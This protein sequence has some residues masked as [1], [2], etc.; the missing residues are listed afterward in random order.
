MKNKTVLKIALSGMFLALGIVLPFLT[1][2]IPEIGAMLC[3]MHIPVIIC[4]FICGWKYGLIMGLI[5]PI[6]RSLM[7]SMPPMYPGA[8]SFA[9]EYGVY[10]LLSGLGFGL[11]KKLN[12][13]NIVYIYIVLIVTMI[14]GRVTWGIARYLIA[15]VDNTI[16]FNITMF[17]AGAFVNAWP[18]IILQLILIP[19]LIRSLS[20]AGLIEKID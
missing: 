9:F 5:L 3:P 6:L 14:L 20:K 12:K 19:I 2:Q 15:L 13:N 1:G 17:I 8:I 7:F 16:P 10:G 11:I 4:G 18:G